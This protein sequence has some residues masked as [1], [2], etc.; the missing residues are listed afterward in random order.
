MA[1]K[2][3]VRE[4]TRSVDSLSFCLSKGLSAPVGS[5][6]CGSGDFISRARRSRK[7]LGGGMRQ[8]GIIA[9]AGITALEE[10][11]D[12]LREDHMNARRL[13]EGVAKTSGLSINPA[14]VQTNIV[15]FELVSDRLEPDQ[16][17]TRLGKKEIKLL[18]TGP[19]RFRMVTHHG[20]HPED[21]DAA[22]A[23]LREV[24][25]RS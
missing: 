1:L 15:Y 5:L 6:V 19:C 25:E 12:R 4:L 24:M 14:Q 9:A 22:L 11:V 23:A 16:L 2:V 7:V 10:M 20:I 17:V 18:R 8:A 3:D 13:A 21:I